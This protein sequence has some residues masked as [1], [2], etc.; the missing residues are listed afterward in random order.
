MA[1]ANMCTPTHAH[2]LSN[3]LFVLV[4]L[5]QHPN[6]SLLH[7]VRWLRRGFQHFTLS[8]YTFSS[9]YLCLASLTINN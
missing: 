8:G 3:V 5:V 9:S 2:R 4:G 1:N 7:Q 6:T